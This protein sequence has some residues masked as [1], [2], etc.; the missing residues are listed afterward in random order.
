MWVYNVDMINKTT[1]KKLTLD[2]LAIHMD[3]R[4]DAIDKKFDVVDKRFSTIDKKF[5]SMEKVFDS[6]IEALAISSQ[7]QFQ[8]MQKQADKNTQII[9]DQFK[10]I[11]SDLSDIKTTNKSRANSEALQDNEII[12]LDSRVTRL[13][14]KAGFAMA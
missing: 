12:D 11:H 2:S 7:N 5:D 4:F 1:K 8:Q 6:K 13:E 9:L 3:N 10:L 14:H